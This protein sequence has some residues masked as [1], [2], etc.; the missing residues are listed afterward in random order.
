MEP[1]QFEFLGSEDTDPS[2]TSESCR[3]QCDGLCAWVTAL[4]EAAIGAEGSQA[5]SWGLQV[6]TSLLLLIPLPEA[7]GDALFSFSP[8]TYSSRQV[9]TKVVD[10]HDGKV[11]SSHEQILRTKN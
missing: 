1:G 5:S 3:L 11:V 6:L 9:R 2:L 8:V 7:S 4:G 10:V